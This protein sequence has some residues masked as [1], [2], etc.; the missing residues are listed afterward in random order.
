MRR[1]EGEEREMDQVQHLGGPK[2]QRE[3]TT[4]WLDYI[5]KEQPSILAGEFRAEGGICHP[6][7]RT[8]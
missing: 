8:L 7:R 2:V 1:G 3:G 5:G 6:G 4:I